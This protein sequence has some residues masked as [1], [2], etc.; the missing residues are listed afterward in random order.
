FIRSDV[1]SGPEWPND[2]V[3][4]FFTAIAAVTGA[5]FF[6]YTDQMIN[7]DVTDETSTTRKP[8]KKEREQP[9]KGQNK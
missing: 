7:S 2:A 4:L 9:Q 6:I 5:A 1:M 8:V 3:S